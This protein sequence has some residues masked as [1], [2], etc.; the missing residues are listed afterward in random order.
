MQMDKNFKDFFCTIIDSLPV[1]I[2]YIDSEQRYRY[3][4][5][6]YEKWFNIK[7][8]DCYG[9]HMRE[10]IGPDAYRAS[11]S[12]IKRVLQGERVS[13]NARFHTTF[14][15]AR[16][17]RVIFQPDFDANGKSKGFAVLAVDVSEE[18][19]ATRALEASK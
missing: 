6:C 8:E 4:N 15:V 7:A 19:K 10:V 3:N 16:E 18:N 5:A 1:C 12:S 14:G 2:S 17:N 13:F 9:K 11:K